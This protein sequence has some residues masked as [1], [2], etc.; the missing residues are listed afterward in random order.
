MSAR[1]HFLAAN[2]CTR[3]MH[4]MPQAPPTAFETAD[5][6]VPSSTHPSPVDP[7]LAQLDKRIGGLAVN[8]FTYRI[9]RILGRVARPRFEPDGVTL[10]HDG[11]TAIIRPLERI[12]TGA[13][14]LF[15]GGGFVLG[16]PD[17]LFPKAAMFARILGVPVICPAYRLAP[18]SPYPA[19]S[20][21]ALAAWHATIANASDMGIDPAR[22]VVGG[23]SAGAGL[24]AS[25]VHRL[26]DLGGNQPAAQL[27]IYPMLDD[28][29][30]MLSALD[31]PRHRVWS[32]R[33]NRFAWKAYL[34]PHEEA[35]SATY[36]VAARRADLSQLPPAWLGVGTCD[37]FLDEVRDYRA[38]LETAGVEVTYDE[39]AGAI[40]G[41]DMD[42]N[43]L[44]HRFTWAQLE[45][46]R[47]YVC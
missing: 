31:T 47:R 29:T 4:T 8:R 26:R 12:G 20:D 41:F 14:M 10:E 40:H 28:R 27:L 43:P 23:Y 13:L 6:A 2:C 5:N 17:D 15:H 3:T 11:H 9:L 36:A 35:E 37:L 24:A 25:L 30:A 7:A 18:Q 1:P 39:V 33:N 16:E 22:I 19:A 34:G 38:R 32:N 46:V 45:F 44:A 21:D 42:D